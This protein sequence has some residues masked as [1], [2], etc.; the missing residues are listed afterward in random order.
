MYL[1][2]SN[3]DI[4]KNTKTVVSTALFFMYCILMSVLVFKALESDKNDQKTNLDDEKKVYE[5]KKVKDE[6]GK[7][8]SEAKKQYYEQLFYK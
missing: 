3:M 1:L 5:Y 6:A 4:L 2:F 8:I 7:E